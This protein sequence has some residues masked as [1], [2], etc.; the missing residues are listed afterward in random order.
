M[1]NS[2]EDTICAPATGHGGAVAMIRVSGPEA[3]AC[4]DRIFRGRNGLGD[5]AGYTMHYGS[6][7][8]PASSKTVDDVVVS[9][10][11]AP[12]SYTGED[13]AEISCHGS[14]YIVSRILA[15]LI[16]GGARMALPGEFTRRAFL[17]GK[18][19]LSQAEA[20]ADL[21]AARTEAAHDVAL[22]QLKGGFSNELAEMRAQ[23]L[24]LSSLIEL[25]LDFSEEDVEFADRERLAVLLDDLL[26]HLT[27]LAD[28]FSLGN[29]LRNGIP[30]VIAGA[31]NSGKSTLLNAL[32]GEERA[33]VSPIPGTTRDTI[34]ECINIG[35][36]LF[37]LTD[38]A[39]IRDGGDQIEQIGI[40][41]A[42][43]K[44][45]DAS[46]VLVLYDLT[47]PFG[48][49]S[50]PVI[51]ILRE[52]T[53]RQQVFVL[54]NKVDAATVAPDDVIA[55]LSG[56]CDSCRF[57]P[58]SARD[59]IGIDGLRSEIA[60]LYSGLVS[61]ETTVITSARHLEAIQAGAEALRRVR[62][63]LAVSGASEA[64]TSGI[65]GLPVSGASGVGLLR[66]EQGPLPT[67]LLAEELRSA[68]HHLGTITGAITT[69]EILGKVFSEFCVGK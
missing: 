51:S 39:G 36:M 34:E 1:H 3:I 38:T 27:R 30:A 61:D 8:E 15:L 28:S 2:F 31:P 40:G 50:E 20:V 17:A 55:R 64:S 25:E 21:I 16:G 4:V 44:I 5:A 67:D 43:A 11:R 41:R 24:Q 23:L 12:H 47:E 59:G 65:S 37:R 52:L 54:L 42:R 46:L 68:L 49:A 6:I 56:I 35:G 14:D 57:L 66:P 29:A 58:V 26:A 9:V 53:P 33:I 62:D 10:F 45:A 13:S 19:D 32:T 63:G 60:S 22:R 7:V 69:D 48:S 18:M